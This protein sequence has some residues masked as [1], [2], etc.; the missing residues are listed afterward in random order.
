MMEIAKHDSNSNQSKQVMNRILLLNMQQR[1]NY[2]GK[3]ASA[4]KGVHY[5]CVKLNLSSVYT[6]IY[7]VAS[8]TIV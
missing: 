2:I 1:R 8:I 3:I 7:V 6:S 4:G 5:I